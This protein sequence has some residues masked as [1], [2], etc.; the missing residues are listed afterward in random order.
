MQS[1]EKLLYAL[2][3]WKGRVRLSLGLSSTTKGTV[4]EQAPEGCN[5]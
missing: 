4:N 5:V 1:Q 3:S 2:Q